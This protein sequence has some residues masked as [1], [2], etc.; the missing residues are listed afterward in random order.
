MS[1][2][3]PSRSC[4]VV[5]NSGSLLK[6][7]H[8]TDIDAKEA[9]FRINYPPIRGFEADVGSRSTFEVVNMHHVQVGLRARRGR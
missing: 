7:G 2:S 4:A 8:G 5:S 6:A 1:V 3:T 9:I